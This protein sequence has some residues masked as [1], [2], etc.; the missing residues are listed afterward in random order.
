MEKLVSFIISSSFFGI[1]PPY[2]VVETFT[3]SA[4]VYG[5]G[6]TVCGLLWRISLCD[7]D[8][9]WFEIPFI[10]CGI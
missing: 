7:L 4:E 9:L 3:A 8:I 6:R 5:F 2:D 1:I 10:L